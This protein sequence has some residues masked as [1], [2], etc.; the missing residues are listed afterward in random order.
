[1]WKGILVKDGGRVITAAH[2][3]KDNLIEDAEVAI[4]VPASSFT[5]SPLFLNN[6][7]F[8][9]NYIDI[10]ISN[11]YLSSNPIALDNCVFTCRNFTFTSSNWPGVSTASGGLRFA[12]T[13]AN[14][15]ASPYEMQNA[16]VAKLKAPHSTRPSFYCDRT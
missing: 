11:N 16:S 12:T 13:Q 1:M 8:N 9:K 7:I 15:L 5:T 4:K 2:N 6:T 14:P 3:N 10:S